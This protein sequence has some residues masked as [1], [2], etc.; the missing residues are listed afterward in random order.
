MLQAYPIKGKRKS[1]LLCGHFING[2]PLDA[3]GSV[4]YG[5]DSSNL[6][7]LQNSTNYY[8]LDNAFFDSTRQQYFRITQNALQPTKIKSSDGQRFN[9]LGIQI[10]PWRK[11]GK[12]I[13]V[14]MQSASFLKFVGGYDRMHSLVAELKKITDRPIIVSE[15]N[16]D[17]ASAGTSL[18]PLL[19]NAWCLVTWS[20][21]A[22]ITAILEGIPAISLGQSAASTM[23][24]D[25]TRINRL[26]DDPYESNYHYEWAC[27][28]ANN[29]WTISEM[30]DGTAWRMLNE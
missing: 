3:S 16:R 17:K 25:I 6:K 10:K 24:K 29:Q 5:I 1:E 13:V 2:A 26:I 9:R 23:G 4:F 21:A 22:A 30:R 27:W 20:S 8:Y 12:H 11:D 18:L 28:L 15:W 19:K 7:A 14:V